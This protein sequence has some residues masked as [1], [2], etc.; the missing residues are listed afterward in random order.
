MYVV[1]LQPVLTRLL[2]CHAVLV[3]QEGGILYA[4][5]EV[6]QN[7]NGGRYDARAA[8]VWSCAIILYVMLFG[9]HPFLRDQVGKSSLLGTQVIAP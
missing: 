3:S 9:R 2:H 4:A 7:A 8:D 6:L 1:R 5:P